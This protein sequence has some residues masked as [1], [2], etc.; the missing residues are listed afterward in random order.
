RLNYIRRNQQRIQQEDAELMGTSAVGDLENIY[1]PSSFLGSNRWASEQIAD[2]LAIAAR[3]GP[4]TFFIT[5]T[6]NATWPEISSQLRPGQTYAD[7][8]LVVIRVFRRKLAL[9]EKTLRNMFPNSG[10]IDYMIRTVEFQK[11]GLPHA[12]ILTQYASSC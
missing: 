8:P 11:R 12:H 6:C 1:L 9:L 7:I 3:F 2:S 4:P 10:G 5:M